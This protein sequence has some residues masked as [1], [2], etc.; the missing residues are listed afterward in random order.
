MTDP[1]GLIGSAGGA[2]PIQP[3][4]PGGPGVPDAADGPEFKDMLLDELRE[5]NKLQQEAT[6]AVEDLQSGKRTDYDA[7]M[8]ATK[9]ADAAFQM[10]LQVR[11]KV[12]DAYNE[13][14]QIRV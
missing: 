3:A 6:Q 11:N 9:K 12:M 14:K 2:S 1:L 4:R 13:V 7:V 5:V 10:L 8:L